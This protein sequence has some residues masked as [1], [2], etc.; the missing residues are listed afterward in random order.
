MQLTLAA[1]LPAR[2]WFVDYLVWILTRIL[3]WGRKWHSKPSLDCLHLLLLYLSPPHKPYCN[4]CTFDD[5]IIYSDILSQYS[6]RDWAHLLALS[7]PS[8]LAF[9]WLQVLPSTQLGLAISPPEFVVAF[10]FWLEIPVFSKAYPSAC[11]F[12]WL[13]VL[14]ITMDPRAFDRIM[15]YVILLILLC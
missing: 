1:V 13:I 14:V 4:L 12:N 6:I 3:C 15:P 11:S 7:D 5:Y 9:A 10:H 8:G 2:N